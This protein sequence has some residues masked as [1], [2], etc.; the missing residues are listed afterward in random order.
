MNKKLSVL[1]VLYLIIQSIYGQTKE[2]QGKPI[3]EIFTDFHVNLSDTTEKTGFGLK[4]AYL[5]YQFLPEGNFSGKIIINIGTPEDLASGSE[6]RRYAY[7]REAS[8]TWSQENLTITMGITGTKIFEFQQKFWGKRYLARPYQSINGY[9][10]VADLGVTVDYIINDLIKTDLTIMNGEGYSNIQLD[11]NI[12]TSLGVTLT[13]G[14]KFEFR[15]YGD[16]QRV[17][18]LWQPVFVGFA[19]YRSELLSIGGEISYKSNIDL[20]EGHHAW[21]ISATGGINLNKKTEL[22]ARFDFVSSIVMPNDIMKWNYKTDGSFFIVG[23]QH[24][25]SENVKAAINYQGRYP[26][27][28]DGQISDLLYLNALFKF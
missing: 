15:F 2:F 14:E 16:I 23:V 10:F 11:N 8:L 21:G 9:G 28:T 19:G 3:A 1:A 13:P 26:Y 27:A 5:G 4:R 20:V 17:E 24:T 18:G 7:F 6:P 25:F 12:R 22:F